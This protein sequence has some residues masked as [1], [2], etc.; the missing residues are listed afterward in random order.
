MD[1]QQ[2]TVVHCD[3]PGGNK[4]SSLHA[5]NC[6][7]RT[8]NAR[9]LD[10]YDGGTWVCDPAPQP[11]SASDERERFIQ[12]M[13]TTYP[14]TYPLE[15]AER[16]WRQGHVS[17]LAWQA[18]AALTMGVVADAQPV[19]ESVV[20]G[21]TP[22]ECLIELQLPAGWRLEG[23]PLE[24][25]GTVFISRTAPS[26]AA[27]AD[28]WLAEAERLVDALPFNWERSI[29]DIASARAAL[30]AHLKTN[31]APEPSKARRRQRGRRGAGRKADQP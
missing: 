21:Y 17:A 26:P 11:P 13:T 20:C 18:R 24:I 6:P 3:C 8:Q 10:P 16:R 9:L 2:L 31:P 30:L 25:G 12:W 7:V 14:N 5:P 29:V 1:K 4:A 19:I 28:E 23:L 22:G 15:D 27:S